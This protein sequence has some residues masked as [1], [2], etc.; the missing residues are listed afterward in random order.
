MNYLLAAALSKGYYL[1][2]IQKDSVR[3]KTKKPFP[4]QSIMDT[5]YLDTVK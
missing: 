5:G 1:I 2:L 3:I 4:K